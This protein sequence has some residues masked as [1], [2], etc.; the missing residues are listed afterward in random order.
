M[1]TVL[2]P[3]SALVAIGSNLGPSKELIHLAVDLL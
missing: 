3:R 2:C 1:A